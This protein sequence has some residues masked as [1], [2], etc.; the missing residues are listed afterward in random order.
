MYNNFR[1]NKIKK[2]EL[3]L[4]TFLMTATPSLINFSKGTTLTS[5]QVFKLTGP[6]NLNALVVKKR[7]DLRK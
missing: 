5:V 3:Y 7:F 2:T 6:L 1:I 4:Y